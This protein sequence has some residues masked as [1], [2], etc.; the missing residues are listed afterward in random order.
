MKDF[1]NW[2]LTNQMYSLGYNGDTLM[3]IDDEED[4]INDDSKRQ[5]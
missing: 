1:L 3:Y 2:E 5:Y 4:I